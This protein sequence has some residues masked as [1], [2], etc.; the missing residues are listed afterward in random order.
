[1]TADELQPLNTVHNIKRKMVNVINETIIVTKFS[2]NCIHW[3]TSEV[4]E[5][6]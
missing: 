4:E 2:H 5:Y 3:M 6:S 1:M